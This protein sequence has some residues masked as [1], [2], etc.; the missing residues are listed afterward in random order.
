MSLPS[1]LLSIPTL[2]ADQLSYRGVA[3]GGTGTPFNISKLDGLEQ[4]D[5]RTGNTDRP[6]S[7]GAFVGLN[8]PKTRMITVTHAIGPPFGSYTNLSGAASALRTALQSDGVTE[9]PLWIQLPASQGFGMVACM[10]RVVKTSRPWD[11]VADLGQLLRGAVIQ[12]EAADPY[13][14]TAPTL[15]PS[16]GLPTPGLGFSFPLTFNWP[17]GGGS[18]ANQVTVTNTG[19]VPCWPVLV[20]NGPCLNPTVQN[21]SIPGN[22]AITLGLQ[23]QTG[24]QLVIDCDMQSILFTPNG[25]TVAAP[26]PQILQAGS[27]FFALPPGSS[28][29]SFNDQ[30]TSPAAGTLAIWNAS[31]LS[32]LL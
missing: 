22:P 11:I 4:V 7:R 5:K 2:G 17:F 8:L 14:Y 1:P 18:T 20:I 13:F 28:V 3:F 16:V 25:S 6:R 30:S 32:G 29:I 23:L 9:Y 31:A 15:A 27:T 19:D 12:F 10:A 21:L 24:D 26:Y